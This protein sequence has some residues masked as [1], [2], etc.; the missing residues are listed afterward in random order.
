MLEK[1]ISPNL[2]TKR[3]R[4]EKIFKSV[5]RLSL[6]AA[7][8]FLIL[9][10]ADLIYKGH[11]AFKQAYV[12]T[13]ISYSEEAR[14]IPFLAVSEEMENIVSR[15]VLRLI[16]RQMEENP[17][18]IGKQIKKWVLADAEVDQYLKGKPNRLKPRDKK[19]V[20]RLKK[21]GKIKLK[22]NKG[23]FIYGDSKLPEM[24]GIFSAFMGTLY[25]LLITLSISFPLGVMAAVYLEEF[26]PDNYFTQL[27][28]VNINNL[29][30]IPS[31]LFGLLGLAIFINFMHIPRSSALVG[32][33][34]L[35]LMS[36]PVIIIS[37]RAALR[38]IPDSIR[39]AAYGLGASRWQMV[40]YQVLPAA[41]PG[42][43]TGT[44]ISLAR[45]IGETAPLLIIG[46]IAYIPD[47][48]K[49]IF[50]AATVLPAQIYTWASASLRAY[51]ERTAAAI[52][53]LL[54]ALLLLN[55][56]AIYFRNKYEQKW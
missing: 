29:A 4:K 56:I 1:Y 54:A 19:V 48:P 21:E 18:L 51:E 47:P 46:M 5:C 28:E 16:P 30:A 13:E 32:G 26:A 38:S 3:H 7:I 50:Q 33:M 40:W 27:I 25:V 34:T 17:A 14:E 20:D 2:L 12:L 23:F 31:I 55:G 41:L 45:A 24:A 44:I 8:L 49:S 53:I 10:F 22:F 43:L 11:T 39:E 35:A 6:Y 36:L 9:F 52:L 37:T 42:I 15:G